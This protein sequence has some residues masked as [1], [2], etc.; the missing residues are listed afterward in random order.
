MMLFNEK[1]K[2]AKKTNE[3]NGK[4]TRQ[5]F[6]PSL[7]KK[8][9]KYTPEG[10]F[11]AE[12]KLRQKIENALCTPQTLKFETDNPYQPLATTMA[13]DEMEESTKPTSLRRTPRRIESTKVTHESKASTND[14]I[15][16]LVQNLKY[17]PKEFIEAR[18]RNTFK[19]TTLTSKTKQD[20]TQ[21]ENESTH[22]THHQ[23]LSHLP[24]T[25]KNTQASTVTKTNAKPGEEWNRHQAANERKMIE[26]FKPHH[27]SL[28]PNNMITISHGSSGFQFDKED[29]D[30]AISTQTID[31]SNHYIYP[32]TIKIKKKK[33]NSNFNDSRLLYAVIEA[34]QTIDKEFVVVRNND[35]KIE[36]LDTPQN[37]PIKDRF[38]KNFI[39]DKIVSNTKNPP[40]NTVWQGRIIAGSKVNFY[41][42]MQSMQLKSWLKSENITL[43]MN[44]INS[45]NIRTVGFFLEMWPRTEL[46]AMYTARVKSQLPTKKTPLF[47]LSTMYLR[48]EGTRVKVI[49]IEVDKEDL[50]EFEHLIELIPNES[51]VSIYSWKKF[52]HLAEQDRLA[53]LQ[54]IN[55]WH[56]QYRTM[57]IKGFTID[58]ENYPMQ[59][60][61]PNQQ[62]DMEIDVELEHFD[63]SE[64]TA[65]DFMMKYYKTIDNTNLFE[66]NYPH[67]EGT[68]EVVV[69]H[70]NTYEAKKCIDQIIV[71]VG[72]H[73]DDMCFSNTFEDFPNID[74]RIDEH[75]PWLPIPEATKIQDTPRQ[76]IKKAKT[77]Y[78]D[79]RYVEAL[80]T[81]NVLQPKNDSQDTKY[82]KLEKVV[83]DLKQQINETQQTT[84]VRFETLEHTVK[85]NHHE[86]TIMN[87]HQQQI[88]HNVQTQ[89]EVVTNSTN[90]IVNRIDKM[91]EENK[92]TQKNI[93]ELLQSLSDRTPGKENYSSYQNKY[94]KSKT[95]VLT[96]IG[97]SQ[98]P[99]QT[100]SYQED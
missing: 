23:E 76:V 42:I 92:T 69:S 24:Y 5:Y 90:F 88:V 80:T 31:K 61:D 54:E 32:I 78:G 47:Q 22:E 95:P 13:D 64:T 70:T 65:I 34:M 49:S 98:Q 48:A 59:Y 53:V 99:A 37:T 11:N 33:G 74:E 43:Q 26:T 55:K 10:V 29:Y 30:C 94:D 84:T 81:D 38:L 44:K 27:K 21:Q 62:K 16:A 9:T 3:S 87:N 85:A 25:I 46:H 93:M 12:A 41:K 96:T 58:N 75:I 56:A 14:D 28:L 72:R 17:V 39:S 66:Y 4:P 82:N 60:R 77:V 36:Y 100:S 51:I 40:F 73:M 83:E 86:T 15:E 19:Q 35:R 79:R 7:Y 2:R 20:K 52:L 50:E 71:D 18:K 91:D 97:T 68:Y 67:F 8:G 89:L 63:F 45:D 6:D 1:T 57:L